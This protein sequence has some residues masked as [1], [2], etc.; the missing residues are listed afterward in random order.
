M[1]FTMSLAESFY[2]K[3]EQTFELKQQQS[4]ERRLSQLSKANDTFMTEKDLNE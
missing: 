1:A 3:N 2:K 4:H